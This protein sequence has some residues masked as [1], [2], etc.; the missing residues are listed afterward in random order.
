MQHRWVVAAAPHK[1]VCPLL[2]SV[3]AFRVVDNRDG[4][5]FRIEG[6]MHSERDPYLFGAS[7]SRESHSLEIK[8]TDPTRAKPNGI[9][10]VKY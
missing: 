3:N 10:H 9:T 8:K 5:G 2:F 7:E 4:V 6:F 1:L